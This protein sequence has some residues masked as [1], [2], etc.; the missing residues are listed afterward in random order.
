M[1]NAVLLI[2]TIFAERLMYLP[3]AF[4]LIIITALLARLL[5]PAWLVIFV[6]ALST[7]YSIRTYTYARPLESSAGIVPGRS[8]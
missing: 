3:S 6:I 2:G 7:F 8:A 4:F 5:R 1:S